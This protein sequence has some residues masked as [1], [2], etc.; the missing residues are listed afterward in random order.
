MLNKLNLYLNKKLCY[1]RQTPPPPIDKLHDALCQLKS[2]QLLHNC[3]NKA[4]QQI[5]VMEL[6]GYSQLT[7]NKQPQHVGRHR[8][9]LPA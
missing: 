9:D 5:E 6:E 4:V 8:C 3:R 1:H 7:C 2:C